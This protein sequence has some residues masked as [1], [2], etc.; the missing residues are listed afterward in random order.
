MIPVPAFVTGHVLVYQ[1]DALTV[2]R[3]LPSESVDCVVTSP[4]Y[5]GLRDYG[6]AGQIGLE[7]TPP[8]FVA[9]MVEVFREVRRVLSDRGT[10]WLNLGDSYA[11]S[12]GH[13]RSGTTTALVGRAVIRQQNALTTRTPEGLKA[14]DMVGIPW[15]VA[16]A[17]QADG[18]YLRSEIIWHKPN[19]MPEAVKDRPTK[20]HETVFLL[21]KQQ[22]YYYD[23]DAI[24]E[25][26]GG[27]TH[28]RVPRGWDTGPGNHRG[29]VGRYPGVG[30]KAAAASAHGNQ[31]R[32][33]NVRTRPRNNESFSAAT[34]SE[35]VPIR[36]SR[37]VWT[38]QTQAHPEAHFATFPDEL[39][40]RCI[41]AGC[42][43]G[44]T[45]LDP[46]AGSGT[47]LAV[48]RDLGRKSIGIE[49]SPEY[50]KLIERRCAQ[51]GLPMGVPA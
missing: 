47:T 41:S 7:R 42:P 21:A 20:A 36:N 45:V 37:S 25:P 39:A 43:A 26:A 12:G 1:G 23:A 48:A 33:M 3:E 51:E 11:S 8:A 15:R 44:G 4:P 50:V 18:W 31:G 22:R 28:A 38:I 34:S 2:L 40:R 6:V 19:A 24:A 13:T 5:W 10:L 30:P 46:F 35:V 9:V 49:L 29:L 14:K 32:P 16:F 17:L 27:N